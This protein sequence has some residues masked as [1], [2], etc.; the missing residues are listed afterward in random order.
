L[1]LI[2]SI[3]SACVL[4][5]FR[6]NSGLDH[7]GL[8]TD[9]KSANYRERTVWR[10]SAIPAQSQNG[11]MEEVVVSAQKREENLQDTAIAIS[12]FSSDMLD[13]LNIVDSSDYEASA[14]PPFTAH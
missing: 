6:L 2:V 9:K 4:A 8:L 14:T 7:A 1:L 5:W 12:A 3:H 10:Q 11:V 13:D